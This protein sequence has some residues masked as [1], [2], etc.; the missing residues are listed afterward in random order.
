MSRPPTAKEHELGEAALKR[1]AGEW[2]GLFGERAVGE[3]ARREALVTYCHAIL[4][5]ASF[6]YL[7]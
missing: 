4:N 6:L 1:F 7:D 5:S 3:T 2:I